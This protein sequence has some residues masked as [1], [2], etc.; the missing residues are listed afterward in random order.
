VAEISLHDLLLRDWGTDLPIRGG[1]GQSREDPIIVE[2][3]DPVRVAEVQMLIFRDLG[4]GRR[5]FWRCLESMPL[6]DE[7]K[8]VEQFKIETV[9]LTTDRIVTTTEAYYFDLSAL[10]PSKPRVP[11]ATVVAYRHESG[12]TLPYEL[13][14][15]HFGESTDNEIVEPG[16]GVSLQYGAPGIKA[17]VYIY[18]RGRNDVP[19]DVNDPWVRAEFEEAAANIAALYPGITPWPDPAPNGAYHFRSYPLGKDAEQG[20]VLLLSVAHGKLVK[21]RATW[22]REP[23]MDKIGSGF[24]ASLLAAIGRARW[25]E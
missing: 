6:G 4:R 1:Y 18:D 5:V 2:S 17:T 19:N 7:W 3:S 11:A 14:L 21:A 20:T 13:G 24:L 22:V 15:L 8:G 16:L 25:K 23:F 12:L 9:E 10:P